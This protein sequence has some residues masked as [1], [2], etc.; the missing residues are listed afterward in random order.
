MAKAKRAREATIKQMHVQQTQ[1]RTETIR[2]EDIVEKCKNLRVFLDGMANK[3]WQDERQRRL[4]EYIERFK[5]QWI[6]SRLREQGK[7]IVLTY[8]RF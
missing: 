1:I 2:N 6:E 5:G 7:K 4:D 3:E 8:Y